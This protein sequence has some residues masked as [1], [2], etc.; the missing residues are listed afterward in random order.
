MKELTKSE[1]AIMNE[2]FITGR[3]YSACGENQSP[4]EI[5]EELLKRCLR[6]K[7]LMGAKYHPKRRELKQ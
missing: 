5:Y 2:A 3:V 6:V 1:E 4:A 7:K